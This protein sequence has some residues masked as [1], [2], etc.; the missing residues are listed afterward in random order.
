MNASER[1]RDALS[2]RPLTVNEIYEETGIA[3]SSIRKILGV[4]IAFGAVSA[5]KNP[6]AKLMRYEINMLL[7]D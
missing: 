5:R 3:L 4:A 7:R 2:E 6:G 1:I